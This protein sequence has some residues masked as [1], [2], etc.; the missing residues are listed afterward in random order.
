V[1]LLALGAHLP[2]MNIGVAVSAFVAHVAEHGIAVALNAGNVLVQAAQ[3]VPGFAMVELGDAAD[4]FP[5]RKRVAVLAGDV[6][7]TVG[8]ASGRG[9][10][11]G[12]LSVHRRQQK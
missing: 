3:G 7:I 10:L 12:R 11:L 4:R 6:Q 5:S 8:T 2:A 1:A 9:R